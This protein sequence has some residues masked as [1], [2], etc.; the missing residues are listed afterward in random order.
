MR[1]NNDIFNVKSRDI[2][3]TTKDASQ[4]KA[5]DVL[6]PSKIEELKTKLTSI[7]DI[8]CDDI[9]KADIPFSTVFEKLFTNVS[10]AVNNGESCGYVIKNCF[11][12][13]LNVVTPI[14]PPRP[15]EIPPPLPPPPP[16]LNELLLATVPASK[17]INS[18]K[19]E[20]VDKQLIN[21]YNKELNRMARFN[22]PMF[23]PHSLMDRISQSTYDPT[24]FMVDSPSTFIKKLCNYTQLSI[25]KYNED[26]DIVMNNIKIIPVDG[27][28]D[29]TQLKSEKNQIIKDYKEYCSGFD[30]T[31]N[32]LKKLTEVLNKIKGAFQSGLHC[33]SVIQKG[34]E[35]VSKKYKTF[36]NYD[37]NLSPEDIDNIQ[38]DLDTINRLHESNTK[39][40]ESIEK[41]E[42]LKKKYDVMGM[43]TTNIDEITII[44]NR[45]HEFNANITHMMERYNEFIKIYSK[46]GINPPPPPAPAPATVAAESKAAD[47]VPKY[48]G[49]SLPPQ[50]LTSY[51]L[52]MIKLYDMIGAKKKEFESDIPSFKPLAGI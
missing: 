37:D 18:V 16:S 19:P 12:A 43:L 10:S 11:D 6:T 25:Q 32:Y 5:T 49:R 27:A 29:S 47:P 34:S 21:L 52:E 42:T 50:L 38:L 1:I 36:E 3:E 23:T 20:T 46:N 26:S 44:M 14:K 31:G 51:R 35:F 33:S 9:N 24:S 45:I 8:N 40:L 30:S 39:Y 28:D 13:I 22:K 41:I 7:T 17:S 48:T 4:V 2:F 15:P